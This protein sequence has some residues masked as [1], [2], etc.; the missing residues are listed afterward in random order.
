MDN[1]KK[2]TDVIG[3]TDDESDALLERLLKAFN[4]S[5]TMSSG[6][7]AIISETREFTLDDALP[8]SRHERVLTFMAFTAG[9]M[10]SDSMTSRKASDILRMTESLASKKAPESAIIGMM[11]MYISQFVKDDGTHECTNCG[12]CGKNDS[13]DEEK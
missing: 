11:V 4:E 1:E 3:I 12:K 8:P 6:F 10:L 2:I 9:R 5:E 7:D 13:D